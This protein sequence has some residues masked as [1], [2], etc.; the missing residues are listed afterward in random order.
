[1]TEKLP[2]TAPE[3]SAVETRWM[4]VLCD[5]CSGSGTEG[6]GFGNSYDENNY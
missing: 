6:L 2:Y 5:S 4:E 1:M 3:A